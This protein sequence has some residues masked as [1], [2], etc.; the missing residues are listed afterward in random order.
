[1]KPKTS[2]LIVI[3]CGGIVGALTV[4]MDGNKLTAKPG[5]GGATALRRRRKA[6]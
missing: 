2:S 3:L 5:H 4:L 1:M 6:E